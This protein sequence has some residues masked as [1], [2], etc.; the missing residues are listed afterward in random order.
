LGWWGEEGGRVASTEIHECME[1]LVK[2]TEQHE[3]RSIYIFM[4]KNPG[5]ANRCSTLLDFGGVPKN[6][7]RIILNWPT[8]TQAASVRRSITTKPKSD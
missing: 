6:T 3:K 7:T 8:H 5:R 4:P 2:L 1:N